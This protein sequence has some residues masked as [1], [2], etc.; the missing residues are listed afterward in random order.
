MTKSHISHLLPSR[1]RIG[2]VIKL[3]MNGITSL[4]WIMLISFSKVL[5]KPNAQE[6]SG[7]ILSL[8]R[9]PR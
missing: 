4:T 5:I 9:D 1:K 3:G 8:L 2:H 7:S 6:E